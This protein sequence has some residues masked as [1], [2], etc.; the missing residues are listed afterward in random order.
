MTDTPAEES[1]VR[2]TPPAARRAAGPV[3]LAAAI[4]L[5]APAARA[6]QAPA[7]SAPIVSSSYEL[8]PSDLVRIDVT[9]DPT[10]SGEQRISD[11]G[12]ITLRLLGEV[13]AA[14]LTPASLAETIERRLEADFIAAAT[15]KVT[16]LEVRSKTVSVVG[17]V[18]KPGTLGY[19]GSWTLLEAITAAG[20]M[21]T[22][23]GDEVRVLRRAANGLSDQVT[24][25]IEGLLLRGEPRYN[26]PILPG[27]LINV[28]RTEK[29][30]IY[31]LGEVAGQGAQEFRST[32]RVTLL[33]AI[34]RAGGLS[35]RASPRVQIK[36]RRSD[37][38]MDEIVANYR[39]ILAGEEP[40][41]ELEDGDIVMVRESFF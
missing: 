11:A 19:P 15:V 23:R 33:T 9:G 22:E 34:A 4:A 25:P 12:T 39:R 40:D 10:L 7:S 31:L 2:A 17:A 3:L 32:D 13:Q 16:V 6:Q 27:D 24:V 38:L 18:T 8:G 26:L 29:V 41:V 28:E 1:A 20:G 30:T 36:R 14:G 37:D 21:T 5:L 35:D